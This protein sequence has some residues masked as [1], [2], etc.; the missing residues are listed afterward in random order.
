MFYDNNVYD[1]ILV[2]PLGKNPYLKAIQNTLRYIVYRMVRL[3][4]CAFCLAL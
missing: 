4:K 3:V 2:Q 1:S